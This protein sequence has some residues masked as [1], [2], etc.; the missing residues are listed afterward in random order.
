MTLCLMGGAASMPGM[1][2]AAQHGHEHGIGVALPVL[3]AVAVL[4]MVV[5]TAAGAHRS[6]PDARSR[7]LL[8][9]EA[10]AMTMGLIAMWLG[11]VI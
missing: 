3:G 5:W 7:A 10:W 9:S 6:A 2:D 8:R 1:P 11:H 4:T